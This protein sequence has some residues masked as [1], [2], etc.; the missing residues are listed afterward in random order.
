M[1]KVKVLLLMVVV[2]SLSLVSFSAANTA[3]GLKI[4]YV[5]LRDVTQEYSKW[6]DMQSNYQEDVEYYQNKIAELQTSFQELQESGAG[7]EELQEKYQE[8]Q[9]RSQQYQQSLQEDYTERS[10]KII[11]EVRGILEEFANENDF[12]ILLFEQSVIFV[13]DPVDIT[14]KAKEFISNY[15]PKE[16]EETEE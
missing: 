12:D 16:T 4:G 9:Y 10:D 13:S 14:E 2:F 1:K 7:E 11:A 15:Q 8:L 3:D 5:N 6:S